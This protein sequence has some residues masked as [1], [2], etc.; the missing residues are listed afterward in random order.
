MPTISIDE[1]IDVEV[2]FSN[3]TVRPR[4][5][6]HR[7]RVIE[8]ETINMVHR[9]EAGDYFRWVFS[10]ANSTAAYRL[11]FDPVELRWYLLDIYA[12]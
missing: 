5:F 12:P 3:P 7:G 1:P 8:V 2:L 6:V 10:V 9:V 11:A 4:A